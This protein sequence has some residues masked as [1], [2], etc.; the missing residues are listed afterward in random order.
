MQRFKNVLWFFDQSKEPLRRAV[1][2][3]KHNRAELTVVDVI[4]ELPR[5]T[6]MLVKVMPPKDLQELVV[7][8]R[9]KQLEK[10]IAPFH[11]QQLRVNSTVLVGT[12]FQEIIREVIRKKRDLVIMTAEG[13]ADLKQ[14]LFGSTSMHLMRK[15]PCPVWVMKP[16]R[17]KRYARI[18]AAVD[19]DSSDEERKLL[20]IKIMDLATSLA[21]MEKSELHIVHAWTVFGEELLRKRIPKHELDEWVGGE[22]NRLEG[23]IGELLQR[24]SLQDLGHQ[25]HLVKGRAG[26]V[27]PA[28][29]EHVSA[30]LLVMGTVCRTGV[31]GLF[32]GNTAEQVLQQVECSVLTVKPD[33]FVTPVE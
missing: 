30:D 31:S 26:T 11:K 14:Q 12:P 6:R 1:A 28:V 15:C 5:N 2:L 19:P 7:N 20:N 23:L 18:V 10:A 3:A 13:K 8:E 16:T 25:I 17:R 24:Y 27:I 33:R 21:E 9:R 29:A 22:R 4:D 32:M